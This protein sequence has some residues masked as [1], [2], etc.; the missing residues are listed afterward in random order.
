MRAMSIF[1]REE[2]GERTDST[3][4]EVRAEFERKLNLDE[5]RER[6]LNR[7]EQLL[8]LFTID[9]GALD[10]L[11]RTR[12]E[13]HAL[14]QKKAPL[15]R[16]EQ[17]IYGQLKTAERWTKEAE[18]RL[19]FLGRYNPQ[20]DAVARISDFRRKDALF[21]PVY[22]DAVE[23]FAADLERLSRQLPL[24]MCGDAL[25]MLD[26]AV[27]L[28]IFSPERATLDLTSYLTLI[29]DQK[30][31]GLAAYL[32]ELRE[33]L[34]GLRALHP[35]V[36]NEYNRATE[37]DRGTVNDLVRRCKDLERYGA[38]PLQGMPAE[39]REQLLMGMWGNKTF[40]KLY[41]AYQQAARGLHNE[42]QGLQDFEWKRR[43]DDAT[44]ADFKCNPH[45]DR[46]QALQ[47][48]HP[49][50]YLFVDV[51]GEYKRKK[52]GSALSIAEIFCL[53]S[54]RVAELIGNEALQ[55][56]ERKKFIL[57]DYL[58]AEKTMVLPQRVDFPEGILGL[59]RF[60]AAYV[61]RQIMG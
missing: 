49:E 29:S 45:Q 9:P 36:D 31:G 44:A 32:N 20:E 26:R 7:H 54:A 57:A 24:N 43:F 47:R 11:E 23:S 61:A 58:P 50:L 12:E 18:Q 1:G 48:A 17:L 25:Q 46:V 38:S 3:H 55:P 59:A 2:D 14:Q 16:L 10:I 4:F 53:E 33:R 30:K 37:E 42:P 56:N 52:D 6:R 40:R 13:L 60:A 21:Q 35:L 27:S 34:D 19:S 28:A 22:P 41:D 51:T 5:E 39:E 15:A 8:R